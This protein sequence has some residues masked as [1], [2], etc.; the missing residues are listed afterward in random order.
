MAEGKVVTL[1]VGGI[2]SCLDA[3]TGKL[4]WRKDPFPKIVPR[5]F[6]SFSPIIV[7]GMVIVHLGGQGN[8]AIIAY[9]LTGGNE[10]WRWAEEGPD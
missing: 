5:F 1:G 6:T 9:G 7:D 8:G 4:V 2:V 3:G 10:K